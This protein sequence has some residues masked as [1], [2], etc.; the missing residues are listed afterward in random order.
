MKH[1]GCQ[2]QPLP[3][4]AA[5]LAGKSIF[6]IGQGIAIHDF[7]DALFPFRSRQAVDLGHEI[8][9]FQN[10]QVAV[11]REGL[12]HVADLVLER[13]GVLR[14]GK[15]KHLDRAFRWCQK[16]GE[17]AHGCGLAA[18]IRTQK[19]VDH[20]TFD[21]QI[22]SVDSPEI[23]E[24]LDQTLGTDDD[25]GRLCTHGR[26]TWAGTPFGRLFALSGSWT[27]ATYISRA[28]SDWLRA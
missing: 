27:S 28:R 14:N 24:F 4:A 1:R 16:S 8:E 12:G 6:Q 18:S 10:S 23:L 15:A 22:Q 9:I 5:H 11:E 17:H 20:A 3:L 26:T 13:F 19:S 2:G 25:F 21:R 7:R